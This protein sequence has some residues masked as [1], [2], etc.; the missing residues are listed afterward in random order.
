MTAVNQQGGHIA[1]SL[2]KPLLGNDLEHSGTSTM[3]SRFIGLC[4]LSLKMA[5][6]H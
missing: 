5:A 2:P 6:L 3:Q 1:K 4:Y